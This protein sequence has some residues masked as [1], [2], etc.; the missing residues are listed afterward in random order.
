MIDPT[1]T[2]VSEATPELLSLWQEVDRAM[3]EQ[4]RREYAEGE[5]ASADELQQ[6]LRRFRR[7]NRR[8]TK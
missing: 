4:E 8:G 2:L 3:I 5:M 6:E 1:N 7:K